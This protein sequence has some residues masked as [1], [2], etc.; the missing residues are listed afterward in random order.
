[1]AKFMPASTLIMKAT[2]AGLRGQI[3]A[4]IT[5]GLNNH[6]PDVIL[7]HIGTNGV[8]TS[9]TDI[10]TILD[11]ID[12]FEAA[13][14]KEIMVILARIINR[15]GYHQITTDYNDAVETMAQTRIANGDYI[16]LVDMEDG[17]GLNYAVQPAGDMW[18]NLHPYTTGY[19]KMAGVWFAALDEFL[20]GCIIKAPAITST[21]PV[22]AKVDQP[23]SYNVEATGN[24]EPTYSL[25]VSPPDMT[26]DPATGLIQ[27]TP[28]A[29][30]SF[31]VMVVAS[32]LGGDDTQ[33]FSVEV[34]KKV[35]LFVP[36]IVR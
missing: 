34:P 11:A 26:I 19:S 30:G 2:P 4:N 23:Y 14:N 10:E 29:D 28:T 18:D 24:P 15:V 12:D 5:T 27:W 33:T 32:N 35:K 17:A 9:I 22:T 21:A 3:A 25:T 7:L 36:L 8:N 31:E 20:D 16:I 13:N 6:S 1:M